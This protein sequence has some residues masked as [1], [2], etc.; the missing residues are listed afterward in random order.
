MPFVWQANLWTIWLLDSFGIFTHIYLSHLYLLSERDVNNR[1]APLL[2]NILL[3]TSYLMPDGMRPNFWPT[4]TDRSCICI[5]PTNI[6]S[7]YIRSTKALLAQ[8]QRYKHPSLSLVQASL[9][10][11]EYGNGRP[12]VALVSIVGCVLCITRHHIT[13]G[14]K[15][16][17]LITFHRKKAE[18]DT[19]L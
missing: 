5:R 13:V 15:A 4:F 18:M 7:G 17:Q 16:T 14:L 2:L 3:L 11:A 19:M 9:L 1:N 8:A 10:L 12:E 6:I